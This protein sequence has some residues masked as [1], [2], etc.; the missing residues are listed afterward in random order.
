VEEV[1]VVVVVVPVGA[2]TVVV[3]PELDGVVVVVP[4]NVWVTVGFACVA[5]V[6][7]PGS[8]VPVA[9]IEKPNDVAEA[10]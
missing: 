7:V 6:V 10:P 8:G 2:V 4:P 9:C 3:V 1:V 5:V